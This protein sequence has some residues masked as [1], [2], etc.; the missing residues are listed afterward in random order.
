VPQIV[1]GLDRDARKVRQALWIGLSWNGLLIL[2]FVVA[3]L[4]V[5]Q[6][7]TEIAIVGIGRATP[8]AVG[9]AGSLFIVLAMLT[10]YWSVSLALSDI[11]HERTQIAPNL[12]WVIATLPT[13][14]LILFGFLDFIDYLRLAGG[15][16]GI[17]VVFITVP[18]YLKARQI[19]PVRQPALSLGRW[20][21]KP[22][23][24]LLLLATV[25][26]AVGS[27]IPT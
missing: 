20:G 1:K 13:A 27:L 15:V 26:M 3:A 16:T 6:P 23:L 11:I 22:V 17:I 7:V 2:F 21:A 5:P 19:G 18:M 8:A 9:V 14:V 4:G 12:A 25:L 10:S 24:W